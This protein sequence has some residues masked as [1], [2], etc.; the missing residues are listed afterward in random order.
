MK[1]NGTKTREV[2]GD[3]CITRMAVCTKENGLMITEM[4]QECSD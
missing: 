4:V 1:E 2:A 3:E